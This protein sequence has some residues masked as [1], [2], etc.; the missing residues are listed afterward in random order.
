LEEQLAVVDAK[1]NDLDKKLAIVEAKIQL[2]NTGSEANKAGNQR[3][4]SDQSLAGA[5]K[6]FAQVR[7]IHSA[8]TTSVNLAEFGLMVTELGALI[9]ENPLPTPELA[10]R[11]KYLQAMDRD[12]LGVWMTIGEPDQY[13]SLMP[14]RSEL[15]RYFPQTTKKVPN[16][17]FRINDVWLLLGEMEPHAS[18]TLNQWAE[19][20][21]SRSLNN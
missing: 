15:V 13:L 12:I 16:F 2:L 20:K 21:A 11:V 6:V 7:R 9:E 4:E 1:A 3:T 8:V 18:E 5:E 19:F 10:D 17:V 14:Q